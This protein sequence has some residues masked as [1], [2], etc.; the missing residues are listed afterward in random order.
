M[1]TFPRLSTGAVAQYPAVR[2]IHFSTQIHRYLDTSE[3]RYR[4]APAS[5]RRWTIDLSR[6]DE[7]EVTR[8]M[9]FFSEQQGRFGSFDFE[10]P[11]T[12]SVVANCRFEQD[13][14]AATA[15]GEWNSGTRLTIVEPAAS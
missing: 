9:E 11:W 10:D 13:H 2:E 8:L 7:S 14:A 5:R 1:S 15:D 6:L 12:G 4:D 3:Q